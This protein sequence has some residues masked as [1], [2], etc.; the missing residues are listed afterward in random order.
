VEPEQTPEVA[1]EDKQP[2]SWN[3][4]TPLPKYLAMILFVPPPF[5]G[6]WIE[7]NLA[8]EKGTVEPAKTIEVNRVATSKYITVTAV[9]DSGWF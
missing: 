9:S 6:G 7:Y 4:V 1:S 3:T 5:I 8:L 2:N